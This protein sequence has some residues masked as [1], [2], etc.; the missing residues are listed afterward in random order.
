MACRV[1]DWPVTKDKRHAVPSRNNLD[2]RPGAAS[3]PT[4]PEPGETVDLGQAAGWASLFDL[5]I[6]CMEAEGVVGNK[7]TPTTYQEFPSVLLP[8]FSA[9]R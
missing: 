7:K 9:K 1:L 3:H 4:S 2:R 5:W 8:F 6:A